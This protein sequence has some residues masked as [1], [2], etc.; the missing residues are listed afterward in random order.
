M[1]VKIKLLGRNGME[2]IHVKVSYKTSESSEIMLKGNWH[3]MHKF[4]RPEA[5][6]G[7]NMNYFTQK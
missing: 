5:G 7:V 3:N 4:L 1:Y 2:A 6:Q